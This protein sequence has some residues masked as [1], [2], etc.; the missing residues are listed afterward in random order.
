MG[1]YIKR[2]EF[3]NPGTWAIPQLFWDAFSNEQRFH[4][5]CKQL[6]KVIA[7]ADYL[8]VNVDDIAARLKAIEEGQLDPYIQQEIED[9]FDDNQPAIMQALSDLADADTALFGMIGTGFTAADSVADHVGALETLTTQQSADIA[10]LRSAHLIADDDLKFRVVDIANGNDDTAHA[11]YSANDTSAMYKTLQKA[12]DD[13][14]YE[15]NDVRIYFNRGGSYTLKF[16][17]IAGGVVHLMSNN[18]ATTDVNITISNDQYSSLF[19]YDTHVNVTGTD[20]SRVHVNVE[21]QIECEGS[22]LWTTKASFT[23]EYLYMIQGSLQANDVSFHC[24]IIARYI[25]AIFRECVFDYDKS[26]YDAVYA[27]CSIIRFETNPDTQNGCT[28]MEN[29]LGGSNSAIRMYTS[30]IFA[31]SASLS[32][33]N[34]ALL[35]YNYFLN[36]NSCLAFTSNA[37]LQ[38]FAG[39]AQS[40]NNIAQMSIVNGHIKQ[41]QAGQVASLLAPANDYVDTTITFDAEF[42][43][44][45]YVFAQILSS[46]A[47]NP[48]LDAYVVSKSNTGCTI[49]VFNADSTGHTITLMWKAEL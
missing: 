34:A 39:Y 19:F 24:A 36:L 10:D 45:P 7:Y 25:Q 4:A 29:A 42:P 48:L 3:W 43:Q 33:Q 47:A 22:T 20:N 46:V 2:F 17:V 26:T 14:I 35:S 41:S 21:H 27:V 11:V 6:G 44:S 12:F 16:R 8:G 28:V 40:G 5:I 37:N 9:W 38:T 1:N 15:G 31:T 23:C 13:A 18:N 32:S 30:I 49:R